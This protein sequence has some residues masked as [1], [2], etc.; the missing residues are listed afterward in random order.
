M[1]HFNHHPTGLAVVLLLTLTGCN[2]NSDTERQA[3]TA[4]AE[5]R[6]LRDASDEKVVGG[7][8]LYA[9]HCAACHGD[10]RGGA[11][12]WWVRDTDG[13]FGP[14]ALNGSAH[15]WHHPPWQLRDMIRHG[16]AVGLVGTESLRSAMPAF[17]VEHGGP[18]TDSDVDALIAYI[19]DGWP[20]AV[21]DAWLDDVRRDPTE[22]AWSERTG[23]HWLISA[24][25]LERNGVASVMAD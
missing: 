25:L 3:A 1:S 23:Q 8:R 18:L 2:S 12:E 5:A 11:P 6:A 17:G 19:V 16:S 20:E 4:V 9:V 14:P 15:S 22:S 21:F 13:R 10:D 24:E 7:Q